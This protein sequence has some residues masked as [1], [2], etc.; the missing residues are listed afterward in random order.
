MTK[1][2]QVQIL[3]SWISLILLDLLLSPVDPIPS[4]TCKAGCIRG[5]ESDTAH[6]F[7]GSPEVSSDP[8]RPRGDLA[9]SWTLGHDLP[10]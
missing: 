8:F 3:S 2:F 1:T 4:S 9:E 6:Y 7:Y 10:G 5:L